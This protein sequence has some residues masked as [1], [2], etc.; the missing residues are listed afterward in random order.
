MGHFVGPGRGGARV[1]VVVGGRGVV[2][3]KALRA[4]DEKDEIHWKKASDVQGS[5]HRWSRSTANTFWR[6]TNTG[7][8]VYMQSRGTL[9][10]YTALFAIAHKISMFKNRKYQNYMEVP[11]TEDTI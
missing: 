3:R 5:T 9:A 4:F 10:M 1:V 6:I 7:L 8:N 2:W 11:F